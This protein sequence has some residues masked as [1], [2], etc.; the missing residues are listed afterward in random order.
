MLASSSTAFADILKLAGPGVGIAT[1][2]GAGIVVITENGQGRT[3]PLVAY[4]FDDTKICIEFIGCAG[5]AIPEGKH[6]TDSGDAG[7]SEAGPER[8]DRSA[9]TAVRALRGVFFR[10]EIF[11]GICGRTRFYI[12]KGSGFAL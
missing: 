8:W 9:I 2:L 1:V 10:E 7:G 5:G 11:T 3:L 12:S 6:F 4:T